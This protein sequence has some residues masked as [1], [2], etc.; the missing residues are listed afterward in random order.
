MSLFYDD[1]TPES[2]KRDAYH[3]LC[4]AARELK[5]DTIEHLLVQ[6]PDLVDTTLSYSISPIENLVGTSMYGSAEQNKNRRACCELIFGA[7]DPQSEIKSDW[8]KRAVG[9]G[10]IDMVDAFLRSTWGQTL[11]TKPFVDHNLNLGFASIFDDHR[12]YSGI[13]PYFKMTELFLES[14]VKHLHSTLVAGLNQ[15]FW[16]NNAILQDA[17]QPEKEQDIIQAGKLIIQSMDWEDPSMDRKAFLKILASSSYPGGAPTLWPL[18]T[19]ILKYA[20]QD[21]QSG[22]EEQRLYLINKNPAMGALFERALLENTPP[23]HHHPKLSR[24][25]L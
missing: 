14:G 17:I 23:T 18:V 4:A 8:L 15:L 22:I 12:S 24:P 7:R 11:L 10:D 16:T 3:S 25:R 13:Y 21:H 5:K 2:L 19:E 6:Y 9:R 20:T 1:P